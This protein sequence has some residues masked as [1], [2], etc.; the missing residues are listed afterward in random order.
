MDQMIRM[1]ELFLEKVKCM[2]DDPEELVFLRECVRELHELNLKQAALAEEML[3]NQTHLANAN[4]EIV[5]LQADDNKR[6]R[7]ENRLLNL[8]CRLF[9]TQM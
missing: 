1:R 5:R 3:Q 6:L 4:R 7:I 9:E 2:R 8:E